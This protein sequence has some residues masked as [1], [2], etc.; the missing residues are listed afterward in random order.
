[1]PSVR[2]LRTIFEPTHEHPLTARERTPAR[3][4]IKQE[5]RINST[6]DFGHRR[7][8]TT[9]VH[10]SDVPMPQE[11]FHPLSRPESTTPRISS[12]D[13]VSLNEGS[14]VTASQQDDYVA[15]HPLHE[16]DDSDV[17]S[18]G[19]S[20]SERSYSTPPE[21]MAGATV[22]AVQFSRV[23][24]ECIEG[25]NAEEKVHQCESP[26]QVKPESTVA[27]SPSPTR[28]SSS[29]TVQPLT[30][31]AALAL[32]YPHLIKVSRY[33]NRPPKTPPPRLPSDYRCETAFSFQRPLT[34]TPF[35]SNAPQP[36]CP[37]DP[38]LHKRMSAAE[39][40]AESLKCA[41][42]NPV[43]RTLWHEERRRVKGDTET[44]VTDFFGRRVHIRYSDIEVPAEEVVEE[45]KEDDKP[46]K[47]SRFRWWKCKFFRRRASQAL[48]AL[49]TIPSISSTRA[50]ET[51]QDSTPTTN[52]PLRPPLTMRHSR[53]HTRPRISPLGR[54]SAPHAP[55]APSLP[56]Q[57]ETLGL[58]STRA[59]TTLPPKQK[60][61]TKARPLPRS[62]GDGKT[63]KQP[64]WR[65]GRR[66]K[67]TVQSAA[68]RKT[69]ARQR[70]G[71][72]EA[73]LEPEPVRMVTAAEHAAAHE[74][75]CEMSSVIKEERDSTLRS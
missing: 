4:E 12:P 64:W 35:S 68:E 46:K 27:S 48:K 75:G 6:L 23:S 54:L 13:Y 29:A 52:E 9:E 53:A 55:A 28:K 33:G 56:R 63:K 25:I 8:M 30:G 66:P 26:A 70:S 51:V 32:V 43:E 16:P 42:D 61:L 62:F 69:R 3:Q 5:V 38:R 36:K 71:E 19:Y 72:E 57:G 15:E 45:K 22:E 2:A 34:P 47:H 14:S 60:K 37:P 59:P 50:A 11:W 17:A 1:M 40:E 20:D 41:L 21:W 18:H 24:P 31:R 65:I 7:R 39:V 10:C 58:V 44:M 49:A 73:P 74:G 67:A